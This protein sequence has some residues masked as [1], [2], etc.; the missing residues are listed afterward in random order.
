LLTSQHNAAASSRR[1]H[2]E[3]RRQ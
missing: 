3:P 2:A 1:L